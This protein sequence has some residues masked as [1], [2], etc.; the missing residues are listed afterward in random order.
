MTQIITYYYVTMLLLYYLKKV[1]VKN[2]ELRLQF[3]KKKISENRFTAIYIYI[4]IYI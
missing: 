3:I 4:Y 1:F 2:I